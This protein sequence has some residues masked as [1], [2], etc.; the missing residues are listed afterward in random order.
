MILRTV[1]PSALGRIM[2]LGFLMLAAGYL[3]SVHAQQ[4]TYTYTGNPFT[5]T[6]C[7]KPTCTPSGSISGS[8]TFDKPL[9][10]NLSA[11][12][13]IFSEVCPSSFTISDGQATLT[14]SNATLECRSLMRRN[15]RVSIKRFLTGDRRKR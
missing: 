10:A 5:F 4:T 2:L 13:F 12:S 14:Q 3:P 6:Y 1:G 8:F 15:R 9:P 11:L 7:D